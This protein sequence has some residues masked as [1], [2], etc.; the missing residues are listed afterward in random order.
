MLNQSYL[1]CRDI[2]KEH[3]KTYYLG[4]VLFNKPK[5]RHICAFYGLVRV[6][7]NIIDEKSDLTLLKKKD[8]LLEMETLLFT[9]LNEKKNKFGN[10]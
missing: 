10:T 2:F 5:F 8:I 9:C 3:A 7:D 4:A 1:L 6:V